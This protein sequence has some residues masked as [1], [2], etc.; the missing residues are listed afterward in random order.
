MNDYSHIYL[1]TIKSVSKVTKMSKFLTDAESQPL[2]KDIINKYSFV[3]TDNKIIVLDNCSR[4][5][6]TQKWGEAT[7]NVAGKFKGYTR[8]NFIFN[9][10][11]FKILVY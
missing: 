10:S 2:Q 7:V 6:I 9:S 5:A 8:S 1:C 4:F 11:Y 3:I